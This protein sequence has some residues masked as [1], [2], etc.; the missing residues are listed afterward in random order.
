MMLQML[1]QAPGLEKFISATSQLLRS[2]YPIYLNIT[3]VLVYFICATSLLSAG[4]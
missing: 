1:L 3:A 4:T 2:L